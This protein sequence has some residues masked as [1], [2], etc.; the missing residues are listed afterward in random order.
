MA[1]TTQSVAAVVR[2]RTERPWRMIAPAPRKPIPVTI[3]A[4]S[5]SRRSTSHQSSVGRLRTERV[6][7][8]VADPGDPGLREVEHRVEPGAAE[9]GPL[10]RR[11]HL[12]ELFV[13]GH[14]DVHVDL[15]PRIL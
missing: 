3:W 9:D 8:G 10:S 12:D 7:L 14:D 15:R 5:A 6:L 11:L 2:P 1:A 13:V 4:A